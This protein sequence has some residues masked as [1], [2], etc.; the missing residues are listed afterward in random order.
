MCDIG[1]KKKDQENWHET[2]ELLRKAEHQYLETYT[3]VV[4]MIQSLTHSSFKVYLVYSVINFNG[5]NK[6]CIID[7]LN[8]TENRQG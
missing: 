1:K 8:R 6:V 3:H 7:R 2:N 4:H 5:D